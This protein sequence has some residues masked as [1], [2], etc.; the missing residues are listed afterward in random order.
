MKKIQIE[1]ILF[2]NQNIKISTF[3]FISL[4]AL[5][6]ITFILYKSRSYIYIY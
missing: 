4:S 5:K 3:E 2:S 1:T 6:S